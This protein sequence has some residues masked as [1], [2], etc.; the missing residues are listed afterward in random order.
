VL[1]FCGQLRR[2]AGEAEIKKRWF[3]SQR[4]IDDKQ[5]KNVVFDCLG[6]TRE[7]NPLFL[8]DRGSGSDRTMNFAQTLRW[9]LSQRS[10]S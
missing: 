7:H 6:Q 4:K 8:L 5:S 9:F 1:R 3:L 2:I 10:F